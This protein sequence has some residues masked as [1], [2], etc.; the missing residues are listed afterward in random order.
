[1]DDTLKT[2]CQLMIFILLFTK[3]MILAPYKGGHIIPSFLTLLNET[4]LQNACVIDTDFNDAEPLF[5]KCPS[6]GLEYF[7][8]LIVFLLTQPNKHGWEILE[9]ESGNPVCLFKNC[10]KLLKTE[11][12]CVV[13]LSFSSPYIEIYPKTT[14]EGRMLSTIFLGLEK[15]K[16]LLNVHQSF[17]FCTL[18]FQCRCSKDNTFHTAVYNQQLHTG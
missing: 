7:S 1:M 4:E 13:T 8:M 14:N 2:V 11:F 9:D 10:T 6:A 16:L 3:L 12:D 15:I 5:I 18:S 17:D